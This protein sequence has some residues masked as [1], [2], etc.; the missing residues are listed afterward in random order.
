MRIELIYQAQVT[1]DVVH[2]Y[3]VCHELLLGMQYGLS[4]HLTPL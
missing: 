3:S 4:S 1:E 2:H